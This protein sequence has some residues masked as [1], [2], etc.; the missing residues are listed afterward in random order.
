[1]TRSLILFVLFGASSFALAADWPRFRGPNGNAVSLESSLPT[2]WSKSEGIRWKAELPARGVSSPVVVG[3]KVYLT[4]S[5]GAKDDRL[6]VLAFDAKTG[7]QLWHRQLAA[8][9]GTNCHPMGGMAATTPVADEQGVYALFPTGD[10]AAFDAD[11]NMR[12]YRSIV[13]DYPSVTNQV[14]MASS[15]ILA[16]GRLIL[17]MD[18]AGESFL[19]GLD[20]KTGQNVWKVSRPKESNWMTPT[21]RQVGD[22]TEILF[23]T[24]TEIA[25]YDATS[26]SKIWSKKGSGGSIPSPSVVEGVIYMPTKGMTAM[27]LENGELKELW[28]STKMG[29]GMSTPVIFDGMVYSATSAGVLRAAEAKT[30]AEKWSERFKGKATASPIAGDGKVYVL[31]EKGEMTVFKAGAKGEILAVNDVGEETLATPAISGGAIYI[32]TDKT[33]FC[34]GN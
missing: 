23:P 3:G 2:K 28:S 12:W 33:L 14:G 29:S 7:K 30:G 15:P 21:V 8:T 1:M 17:P 16:A 34:V 20:T 5:S 32:R 18:N 25:A 24:N 22:V 19:A 9:G 11:G 31:N 6:H 27:K 13:S 26:G 4:C 10:L